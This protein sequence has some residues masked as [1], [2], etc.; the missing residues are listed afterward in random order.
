MDVLAAAYWKAGRLTDART[1]ADAALRTGSRDPRVLWHAAEIRA[2][3]G[4]PDA[5]LK[6]LRKIP[7]RETIADLRV[8][9]GVHALHQR[10]T[11]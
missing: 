4:E 5:A 9:T 1:A 6:L 2:A 11:N 10:L 8:R 7:A 3:A